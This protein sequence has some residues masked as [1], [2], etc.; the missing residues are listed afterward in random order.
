MADKGFERK[1]TAIISADAV[2]YS[3]L[4]GEDEEATVLTL[5]TYQKV[6]NTPIHQHNGQMLDSP[7]DNLL[8]ELVSVVDAV[9]C[10]VAVQK[11]IKSQ[12]AY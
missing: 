8:A 1:L 12:V 6:L 3:R 7:G 10:A 11:E 5:K 4:I 2:D 9:Q